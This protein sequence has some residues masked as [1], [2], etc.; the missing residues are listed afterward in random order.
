MIW[1]VTFSPKYF[2]G[3]LRVIYNAYLNGMQCLGYQLLNGIND[4]TPPPPPP[5][6]PPIR[7]MASGTYLPNP[8]P[9]SNDGI[10]NL[11]T[12]SLRSFTGTV[13]NIYYT[14][15]QPLRWRHNELDGISDHHPHDCL[16]NL[17]FMRRSKKTS[18]LRVTGLCAGNSPWNGEF[19]AQKASDA[20]NVPI[21]WRHHV[22]T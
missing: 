5:P 2:I 1:S 21:W 11:F 7:M 14:T 10:W 9:H 19:P 13:K 20:K 6:P 18:K 15:I 22:Y 17:L 4:I 3:M 8:P 12:Q 16:L